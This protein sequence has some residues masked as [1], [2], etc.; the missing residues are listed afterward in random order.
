MKDVLNYLPGVGIHHI[1]LMSACFHKSLSFFC[2]LIKH[3]LGSDPNGILQI[4]NTLLK[5]LHP[6]KV[7]KVLILLSKLKGVQPTVFEKNVN[8]VPRRA[9]ITLV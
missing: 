9:L 6:H 5:E 2:F 1:S 4:P 7:K 3:L 8:E